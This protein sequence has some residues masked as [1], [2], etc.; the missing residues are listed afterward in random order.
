MRN[1]PIQGF[2]SVTL[3][4]ADDRPAR[5]ATLSVRWLTTEI[6]APKHASPQ[7]RKLR[8]PITAILVEE[9][10]PPAGATPVRW[11]LYTTLPITSLE[12]AVQV[13]EYYRQ[14]WL[15][16]R[17]HYVLKS[18]CQIEARQLETANRFANALATYCLIAWHLM[19][20]TYQARQTPEASC[21]IAFSRLEWQTLAANYYQRHP[22]QPPPLDWRTSPPTLRQAILWTAL[23]GGFMGRRADGHPGV[24][25]LWRGLATLDSMLAG[26]RLTQHRN[27]SPFQGG[28]VGNA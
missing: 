14:R 4:R 19:Y 16:E 21:E 26:I 24:V 5:Q 9:D 2:H 7:V 8:A 23:L 12:D 10:N 18:G 25:S 22:K 3:N 17:F 13:V 20:L 27:L 28:D 1:S 6:H 15:I 11:L